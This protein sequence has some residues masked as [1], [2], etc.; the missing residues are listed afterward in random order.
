MAMRFWFSPSNASFSPSISFLKTRSINIFD[1]VCETISNSL[2][3]GAAA[4]GKSLVFQPVRPDGFIR[5]Q[6]LGALQVHTHQ[7]LDYLLGFQSTGIL[8]P[9]RALVSAGL[10]ARYTAEKGAE[11]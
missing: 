4:S 5:L 6:R 11:Q 9:E 8:L 10:S 7:V 3:P 1:P 2:V